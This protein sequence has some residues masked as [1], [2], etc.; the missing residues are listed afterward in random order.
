MGAQVNHPTGFE[1]FVSDVQHAGIAECGI[2]DDVFDVK[3][4]I[5][6]GKLEELGGKRDFLTGVGGR[7]IVE[8]D[9]VKA[10]GGISEEKR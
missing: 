5:V 3:R 10:A 1:G 7:E 2:T 6:R 4:G 9:E 8:Q